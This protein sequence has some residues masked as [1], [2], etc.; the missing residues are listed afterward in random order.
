MVLVADSCNCQLFKNIEY[1]RREF[2][3]LDL[4][5]MDMSHYG[6]GLTQYF[7]NIGLILKS[8]ETDYF[9]L[10]DN[11]DFYDFNVLSNCVS[12]LDE[13]DDYIAARGRAADFWIYSRSIAK[14]EN[15]PRGKKYVCFNVI[16]ESIDCNDA[17]DRVERFFNGIGNSD[18]FHNY[19]SVF[20]TRKFKLWSCAIQFGGDLDVFVYEVYFLAYILL[21]G[22][23]KVIDQNSYYR[24]I[25][26]S[27]GQAITERDHPH[28]FRRMFLTNSWEGL[29][30]TATI[31]F[32]SPAE[33]ESILNLLSCCLEYLVRA[34]HRSKIEMLYYGIL[35][36]FRNHTYGLYYFIHLKSGRGRKFLRSPELE[37]GI[38][39]SSTK[40]DWTPRA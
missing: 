24:Q 36:S 27:Q 12:F 4:V 19:Y 32:P 39:S 31:L 10:A 15:S 14:P 34:T 5:Y 7:K 38:Q 6:L 25:G 1:V 29:Y 35:A 28:P 26:T 17:L 20:R 23:L 21:Y 40:H 33:R 2:P 13:N 11:D 3:N 8:I 22:K 16:N 37:E 30:K 9:I 18:V